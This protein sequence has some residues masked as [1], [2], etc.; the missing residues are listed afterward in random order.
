M[1]SIIIKVI[2]TAVIVLLF[3]ASLSGIDNRD[4]YNNRDKK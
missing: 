4:R 3:F 2:F 1:D